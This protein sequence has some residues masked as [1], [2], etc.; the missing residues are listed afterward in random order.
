MSLRRFFSSKPTAVFVFR[1]E[2]DNGHYREINVPRGFGRMA[3]ASEQEARLIAERRLAEQFGPVPRMEEQADLNPDGSP[4]VGDD[5]HPATK[6]V[7]VGWDYPHGEDAGQDK[8]R[9]VS[10]EKR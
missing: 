1:Y 8:Y 6:L 7:P 5:G 10:V 3:R 9:L 2:A 4:V